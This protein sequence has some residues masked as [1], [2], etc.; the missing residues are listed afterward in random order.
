MKPIHQTNC[1]TAKCGGDFDCF[2]CG[3]RVGWCC[4]AADLLGPDHCDDC[5]FDRQRT[6]QR[7]RCRASTRGA[8][9]GRR[10]ATWQ[11]KPLLVADELREDGFLRVTGTGRFALTNRG[12]ETLR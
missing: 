9:G 2:G 10:P 4:G 7:V 12:R 5:W 8:L 11:R 3:R 6:L 1:S